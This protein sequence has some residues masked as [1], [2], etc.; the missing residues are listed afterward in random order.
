MTP[1]KGQFGKVIAVD[2]MDG[3]TEDDTDGAMVGLFEGK[4]EGD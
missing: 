2:K 1:F 4:I 3:R